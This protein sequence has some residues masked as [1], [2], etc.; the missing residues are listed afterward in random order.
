MSPLIRNGKVIQSAGKISHTGICDLQMAALSAGPLIASFI[1][2][3][4]KDQIIIL[5]AEGVVESIST[6]ICGGAFEQGS[7]CVF[8]NCLL[9]FTNDLLANDK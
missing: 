3:G 1:R 5:A 9:M 2:R 6:D 8:S 4:G 7:L